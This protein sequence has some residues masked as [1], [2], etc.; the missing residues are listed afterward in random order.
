M[1]T[2]ILESFVSVNFERRSLLFA[3]RAQSSGTTRE[4][5]PDRDRLAD[6]TKQER[7]VGIPVRLQETHRPA[8]SVP[9]PAGNRDVT[10]RREGVCTCVLSI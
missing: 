4:D 5:L 6:E 2:Y 3:G 7:R 1:Y 10:R 8:R 9:P